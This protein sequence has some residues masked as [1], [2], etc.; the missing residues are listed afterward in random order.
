MWRLEDLGETGDILLDIQ[1]RWETL[2]AED[3][4]REGAGGLG[5]VAAAL[6]M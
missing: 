1:A 6:E 5:A 3:S 2:R 4:G